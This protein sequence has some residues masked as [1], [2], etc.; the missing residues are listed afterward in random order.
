[1][2][3]AALVGAVTM[4]MIPTDDTYSVKGEMLKRMVEEDKAAGLIPF[5]VRKTQI[6]TQIPTE[7]YVS[8]HTVQ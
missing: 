2:E 6:F 5:Y 8:T 7:L 4:R 3:R 1:M